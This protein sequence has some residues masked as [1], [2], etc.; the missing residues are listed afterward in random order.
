M[1][2]LGLKLEVGHCLLRTS[3]CVLSH[4]Y[5]VPG[6]S[7]NKL[8]REFLIGVLRV[9]AVGSMWVCKLAEL[10]NA[11]LL[12][13]PTERERGGGQIWGTW[14][15]RA[16]L[17]FKNSQC[18]TSHWA[19]DVFKIVLLLTTINVLTM[20]IVPCATIVSY[21]FNCLS[22]VRISRTFFAKTWNF[23]EQ[24]ITSNKKK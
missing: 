15:T 22:I 9:V 23:E 20:E 21:P 4:L 18:I 6:E 13:M 16:S 3:W 8:I 2:A 19:A 5:R 1:W 10:L 17:Q 7:L 12:E 11:A 24:N 14:S